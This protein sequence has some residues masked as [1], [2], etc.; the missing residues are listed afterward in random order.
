VTVTNAVDR[1]PIRN[2]AA[3]ASS[4]TSKEERVR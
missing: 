2:R 4:L 3:F 1:D